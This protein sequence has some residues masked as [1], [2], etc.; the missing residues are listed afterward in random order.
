MIAVSNIRESI[1]PPVAKTRVAAIIPCYNTQEQIGEVV[2]KTQKYVDQVIVVDDGSTDMTAAEA[3]KAGARVIQHNRNYG[4][5]AAMKTGAKYADADIIVFIDGDGQHNPEDISDMLLPIQQGK[6]DFVIG[7][8]Y[9]K[10]SKLVANPFKRKAANA[11]ASLFI[12]LVAS[13]LQPAA[14]FFSQSPL[15][16]R[17]SAG[18][19][20]VK[21]ESECNTAKSSKR[22]RILNGK[23]KW[24]SDCTSGFTAVRKANWNTLDLISERYQ[25]E[26]EIIFEQVKHG[27]I[28][29]EMPIS[30]TWGKSSSKLSIVKDG[31]LTLLMLLN[32][33]V[34]YSDNRVTT[35]EI[36]SAFGLAK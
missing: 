33:L 16:K 36:T 27:S 22:Y 23:Y 7:S 17:Q 20:A 29:A 8:R 6:A 28:I 9:L 24:I 21:T 13:V 15:P 18:V 26:T 32:K 12:S 10:E 14:R 1:S 5:G 11:A 3:R 19:C 34:R 25:I 4:K 31:L 35:G 30:C 2:T